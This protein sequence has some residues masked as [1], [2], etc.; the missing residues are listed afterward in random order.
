[1][2]IVGISGVWSYENPAW[3]HLGPAFIEVFPTAQL[4]IEEETSCHPWET[5][6]LRSF[7]KKIV[8][9]H[10]DGETLLL[11]GHSMGGVIACA[12]APLFNRSTVCG[13]VTVFAPH[14]F[15]SGVF[16]RL[17]NASTLSTDIPVLSFSA[18]FDELVWWGAQHP[19]SVRHIKLSSNHLT[20]LI[21]SKKVSD[22]IAKETKKTLFP[23]A[24]R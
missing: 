23:T 9:K 10:D 2:R 14:Q 24:V 22:T 1:V 7:M 8:A 3:R 6:R 15:L 21:Y 11:A 5:T 17:L 16:P 12:S 18:D 19:Q 20:D 13:V 4:S